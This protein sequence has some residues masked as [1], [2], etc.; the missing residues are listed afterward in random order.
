MSDLIRWNPVRDMVSLRNEVDRLFEEAFRLPDLRWERPVKWDLALDVIEKP[1]GF[2]VKASVP[3]IKPEDLEVTLSDNLLT[4][5]G[6]YKQE[7]LCN[8]EQYHLRERRYGQFTRSISL[9]MP[10]DANAIEA[11]FE[12]GVLTLNIPKAE[13]VKPLR[14]AV[15]AGNG[16]HVVEG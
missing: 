10:V 14:I 16:R 13:A 5:K 8:D 12:Q 4:I 6:E 9:P 15:K 11:V 3:G 1:E 2:V 7:E